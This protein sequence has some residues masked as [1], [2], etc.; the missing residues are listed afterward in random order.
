[1]LLT[2]LEEGLDQ[3]TIH[4]DAAVFTSALWRKPVSTTS[5]PVVPRSSIT[6][7][8][9]NKEGILWLLPTGLFWGLKK[10]LR[11][12]SSHLIS[13]TSFHG[14]TAH[15]FNLRVELRSGDVL[16]FEAINNQELPRVQRY[17]LHLGAGRAEPVTMAGRDARSRAPGGRQT[18]ASAPS[19]GLAA[20]AGLSLADALAD[21]SDDEAYAPSQSSSV[22][23][24][25]D[26]SYDS[27]TGSQE[28]EAADGSGDDDTDE[29]E[30]A[31][32]APKVKAKKGQHDKAKKGRKP[33]SKKE[34][35]TVKEETRNAIKVK[36]EKEDATLVS[37]GSTTPDETKTVEGDIDIDL[38]EDTISAPSLKKESGIK[39]ESSNA[40]HSGVL[41]KEE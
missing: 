4:Q 14:G 6:A 40:T 29:A 13:D 36:E 2:A 11:Y 38:T 9:K 20:A 12:L 39:R 5:E 34:S 19:N 23:E 8:L 33:E 26:S 25:Y 31:E 24:D 7:M 3:K 16:D 37:S 35:A 41:V 1:M 21:E 17:I 22:P 27:D 28:G 10:P 30:E 15:N 18:A 32:E